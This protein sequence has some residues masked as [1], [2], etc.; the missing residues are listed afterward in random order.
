MT[1]F[2]INRWPAVMT[3]RHAYSLLSFGEMGLA[4][5]RKRWFVPSVP[6][7]REWRPD[8]EALVFTVETLG[9]LKADQIQVF[10]LAQRLEMQHKL[11]VDQNHL[12]EANPRR[13]ENA[14]QS[15]LVAARGAMINRLATDCQINRLRTLFDLKWSIYWEFQTLQLQMSSGFCSPPWKQ[16]DYLCIES[17]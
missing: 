16:T 13:H 12:L 11:D 8:D 6:K 5:H 17:K 15:A 10:E 9:W 4:R 2:E 14:Q 7:K 3:G 1:A